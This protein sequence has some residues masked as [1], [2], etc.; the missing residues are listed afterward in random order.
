MSRSAL[1][2]YHKR[3]QN[4][5]KQSLLEGQQQSFQ[6]T[7][8]NISKNSLPIHGNEVNYN[9][10]TMLYNN[11]INSDYYQALGQLKNFNEV[12][13][14]ISRVVDHVE[15]W[16]IGTSRHPSS[17]FCLLLK[18]LNMRLTSKQMS[19]LLNSAESPYVR[20]IGFLYLR[21]A[22]NPN[23]LWGWFE[24]YLEDIDELY[25]PTGSSTLTGNSNNRS[26]K[27][28]MKTFLTSLLTNMNYCST[29]LPRIPVLIE[30]KMKV[31]LLVLEEKI[32][33]KKENYYFLN[34]KDY[35]REFQPGNKV[36]AYFYDLEKK[37][38]KWYDGILEERDF[39]RENEE[40]RLKK[41]RNAY[42]DR[43]V[44]CYYF[45]NFPEYDSVESI[46]LG[47]IKFNDLP[48]KNS[49][50]FN[51]NVN[52]SSLMNKVLEKERE[53]SLAVG[54]NYSSKPMYYKQSLSLKLDSY[55]G[56]DRSPIRGR[57]RS[58]EKDSRNRS[59]ERDNRNSRERGKERGRS[60]SR[61]R[62][63]RRGRSRS[64]SRKRNDSRS[65]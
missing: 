32:K 35:F 64:N 65:R 11:I 42:D 16:H 58:R 43:D 38:G 39:D 20:A 52:E 10:N 60:R 13:T 4:Q 61:S 53:A 8:E 3:T 56:R 33:L 12:Q 25:F 1:E 29:T 2:N 57:N 17:A 27:V 24:E 23:D 48:Y 50:D 41:K 45:V 9:I 37:E 47:Y 49:K 36:S 63:P 40:I 30:R 59:R 19:S 7:E 28:P 31:N 55:T 18:L 15:P 44:I 54:K 51:P 5:L 22:I 14:E 34:N 21:Y 6:N 26:K 62:S 46:D